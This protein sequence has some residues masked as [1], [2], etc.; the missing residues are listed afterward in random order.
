L[1]EQYPQVTIIKGNSSLYW[2]GGMRVAFAA[3]ERGFYYY[4]R[5]N[6]NTLH[7]PTAIEALVTMVHDLQARPGKK[8]CRG[9]FCS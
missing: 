4:L 9:W 6:D 1:R 5:L 8:C 2:N 3:T 7:Y